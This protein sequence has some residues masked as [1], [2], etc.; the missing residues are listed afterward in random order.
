MTKLKLTLTAATM[1]ILLSPALAQTGP[2][3][4]T[5]PNTPQPRSM[6][7]QAAPNGTGSS[8]DL[9]SG[10]RCKPPQQGN[11]GADQ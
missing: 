6:P 4:G 9:C 7:S 11:G 8:S 1:A 5:P 3:P 10:N 2:G